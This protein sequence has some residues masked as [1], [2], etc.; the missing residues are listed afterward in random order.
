MRSLLLLKNGIQI[1]VEQLHSY[2]NLKQVFCSF[3]FH[4]MCSFK[5]LV[6]VLDIFFKI[7]ILQL[8]MFS[9]LWLFHIAPNRSSCLT[10]VYLL[11]PALFQEPIPLP[12]ETFNSTELLQST[13]VTIL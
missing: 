3:S 4:R 5:I 2:D 10:Y 6:S 12:V 1:Y 8:S 7:F 13:Q 9:R 11:I